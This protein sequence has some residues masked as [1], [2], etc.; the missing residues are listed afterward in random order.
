MKLIFR[1]LLV[2]TLFFFETATA[3]EADCNRYQDA[4][5]QLFQ[6]EYSI[7]EEMTSKCPASIKLQKLKIRLLIAKQETELATKALENLINIHQQVSD[8]HYFSGIAWS[9]LARQVSI[10]SK[11][12]YYK[13]ATLA[14]IRAAHLE[15]DNPLFL[16][17]QAKAYGQP[18]SLGGNQTLQAGVVAKLSAMSPTYS[19]LAKMDLAQNKRDYQQLEQL[20]DQV[21]KYDPTNYLIVERAA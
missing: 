14:F 15:P 12:R 11:S 10:F 7:A 6:E 17:E 8:V 2:I 16:L 3:T 20:A 5:H 19:F 4:L 21:V 18:D 1:T 9:R 13:K